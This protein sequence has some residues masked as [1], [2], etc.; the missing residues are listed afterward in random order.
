MAVLAFT[1][2]TDV[3]ANTLVIPFTPMYGLLSIDMDI[4]TLTLTPPLVQSPD[5]QVFGFLYFQSFLPTFFS[6]SLFTSS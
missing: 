2:D 6:L 3:V 5:E 4:L 1:D